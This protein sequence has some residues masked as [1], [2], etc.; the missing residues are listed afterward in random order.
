MAID[1]LASKKID[2]KS[3]VT[4]RFPLEEAIKAFETTKEGVGI[5]IMLK[6]DSSDQ[7]P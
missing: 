3:L 2:V 5:K 4:H 6:C 1:M 7:N